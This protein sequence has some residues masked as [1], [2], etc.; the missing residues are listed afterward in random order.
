M[1]IRLGVIYS[2]FLLVHSIF[3]VVRSLTSVGNTYSRPSRVLTTHE[4]CN[5]SLSFFRSNGH[6]SIVEYEFWTQKMEGHSWMYIRRTRTFA[7]VEFEPSKSWVSAFEYQSRY[8]WFS[9]IPYPAATYTPPRFFNVLLQSVVVSNCSAPNHRSMSN[10]HRR[11]TVQY[12]PE[13]QTALYFVRA[14]DDCKYITFCSRIWMAPIHGS[15]S[16]KH[17][18]AWMFGQID[19]HTKNEF[20]YV[21]S[22]LSR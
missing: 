11:Q 22:S 21:A 2:V 19:Y 15:S 7:N 9:S 12:I 20:D 3:Q 5:I 13:M 16:T 1:R 10:R 6:T 18:T 4:I 17:P 8:N 14:S